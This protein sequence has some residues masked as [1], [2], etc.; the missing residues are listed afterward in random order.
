VQLTVAVTITLLALAD[1]SAAASSARS[2][3]GSG[4]GSGSVT[5]RVLGLP[6]N[7]RPAGVLTG[8]HGLRRAIVGRENTIGHVPSGIYRLTL[9]R[10]TLLHASGAIKRGATATALKSSVAVRVLARRHYVLTG[11]YT[12]IVNPGLKVLS[13]GVVSV[14]GAPENP[15]GV[16][17]KGHIALAHG[18]VLSLPPSLSLPRGLLS[19]VVA[20]AYSPGST[21]V[22]LTAAS[23]YQV[24]P[25]FEFEVPLQETQARAADVGCG[26]VSGISPYRRIKN[27]SFS[28]GWSTVDVFGVHVTD[29]V[30]ASVRFDVEGGVDVTAAAGISCSVSASF[31]ADG[32]AGPIPVTAGIEGDLSGSVAAGGALHTGGSIEVNAGGHTVGFPPAL[33]LIPDVSFGNPHFVLSAQTIAQAS[34]GIGLTVKA[35]IG[36][37]GVGSVTLNVG[38]DL[39]FSAQPGLCKWD[40]DFGAFSAEG[41]LLDWHLSTPATPPLFTKQ[42]GGNFCSAPSPPP[43][44]PPAPPP[45]PPSPPPG[46]PRHIA[47]FVVTPDLACTLASQEDVH[48]E[49]YTDGSGNDACGTFIAYRGTLY[50]PANIPAGEDLGSYTPWMPSSQSLA[51][52]GTA[53]DPYVLTTT[54]IAPGTELHLTEIDSW[55]TGG[56]E[57]NSIY[58]VSSE[59]GD[60]SEV[61]LYHAQD[62]YAGESDF[63][64]GSFDPASQ[65]VGCVHEEPDGG[66]FQERLTPQTLGAESVEDFYA[67]IWADVATQELLP[68]TCACSQLQDNGAATSWE[69]PLEGTTPIAHDLQ[70]S[71][72]EGGA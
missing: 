33:L 2:R 50:G 20:V 43:T 69:F 40:A 70:F 45:A 24:A 46:A 72:V 10:V 4:S 65:S 57:I 23:I 66:L 18:A 71:F 34:A 32:M 48:D 7:E 27:V 67:T 68:G 17:L 60:T 13:G 9:N 1:G 39:E 5:V 37:G 22:S 42:L 6:R 8:P 21:S 59:G 11:R 35:G 63:G 28:G 55:F 64:T 26:P 62:C 25:N 16:V 52:A 47:S 3:S 38:T 61:T 53:S 58:R 49:L 41:E 19:N 56:A 29:G 12:T 31:N 51:G 15:S 44:S 54:V 36:M 14:A 30:R